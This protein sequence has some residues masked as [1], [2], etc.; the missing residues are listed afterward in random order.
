MF[1]M[2][3]NVILCRLKKLR[4]FQLREPD[5]FVFGTELNLAFAVFGCVKDEHQVLVE[6]ATVW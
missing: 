3:G 6:E 1:L 5:G 2:Y 4:Y